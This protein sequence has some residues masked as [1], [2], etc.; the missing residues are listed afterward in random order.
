MALD[1]HT[2]K[3]RKSHQYQFSVEEDQYDAFRDAIRASG[4]SLHK[5]GRLQDYYSDACFKPE[6]LPELAADLTLMI[7][8]EGMPGELALR[9]LKLVDLA[10]KNNEH[11][12]A[13][14]D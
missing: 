1:I 9:L 6:E 12:F 7:E 4:L 13:F 2:G 14:A 5:L 10:I 11:V 8:T 3:S